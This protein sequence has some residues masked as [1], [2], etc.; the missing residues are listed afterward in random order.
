MFHSSNIKLWCFIHYFSFHFWRHTVFEQIMEICPEKPS[1]FGIDAQ[2]IILNEYKSLRK[3]KNECKPRLIWWRPRISKNFWKC[4]IPFF[5]N[6]Q[7]KKKT[8][9]LY[10]LFFF[11][12]L[13]LSKNKNQPFISYAETVLEQTE[14]QTVRQPAI[15]RVQKKVQL[16]VEK[17]DTKTADQWYW[18]MIS[19]CRLLER[20]K[21]RH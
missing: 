13:P 8:T 3:K 19:E 12:R 11:T 2:K 7:K 4:L 17:D 14:E 15:K 20:T 18:R 1:K 16:I 9:N 6:W 21:K 10:S 5:T